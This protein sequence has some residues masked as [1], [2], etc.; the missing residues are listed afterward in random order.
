M[1]KLILQPKVN[2]YST[3]LMKD[4]EK[5]EYLDSIVNEYF[6]LIQWLETNK[7]PSNITLVAKPLMMEW[8][9]T[10]EF[11]LQMDHFFNVNRE[12]NRDY[13]VYFQLWLKWKKQLLNAISTFFQGDL[14]HLIPEPVS[15]FPLTHLQTQNGLEW[16]L[17]ATATLFEKQFSSKPNGIWLPYQSYIPGL[18]QFLLRFGF[19]YTFIPSFAFELGEKDEPMDALARSPRGL[20]LIPTEPLIHQNVG[21]CETKIISLENT[22]RW[23]SFVKE[24]QF[25]QTKFD[26]DTEQDWLSEYTTLTRMNFCYQGMETGLAILDDEQIR[27]ARI[28]QELELE[29]QHSFHA[30]QDEDM[31]NHLI[32]EWVYYLTSISDNKQD[33][34][35]LQSL[36]LLMKSIN[37][38]KTESHFLQHRKDQLLFTLP[39][40]TK[41]TTVP[42]SNAISV[43]ILSWEFPPNIVGGLSRHVYSLAKTLSRRGVKVV[44]LTS[45]SAETKA[46]EE[47][48]GIDVYRTGPLHPLEGNFINWVKDLNVSMLRKVDDII[49]RHSINIVHAHDWLVGHAALTMKRFYQIPLITTIHATEHG[50][51]AG[52]YT[53]MQQYIHNEES[54]L[55]QNSNQVIVCSD[56]MKD[57]VE[58][59]FLLGKTTISIIPNGIHL[60]EVEKTNGTRFDYLE[61]KRFVFSVGR[62]VREKGF[63]TLIDVASSLQDDLTIIVA[64]K[65]PL[66]DTYRNIVAERGLNE[67]I[68]FIGFI[69]DEERNQL[70]NTCEIAIFPSLYEPFGIVALE[71]MAAKKPVIASKI[72]GLKGIIQHEFSGLLFSPGVAEELLLMINQLNAS[73]ILQDKIGQQGFQVAKKLF[74][75]ERIADQTKQ[76]YEEEA[77]HNK[78]E[79]VFL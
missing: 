33:Q 55:I 50:R 72:G 37:K 69:T 22:K 76:V 26:Q 20:V 10:N 56:Y 5:E 49:N 9:S 30:L 13:Q 59:L 35:S 67:K 58:Q 1:I 44:V 61:Q 15:H 7:S 11:Q 42:Q 53:E 14:L 74:G 27:S 3:H 23:R 8:F 40:V 19:K 75:W 29:I 70:L 73:P 66:L 4:V 31:K 34:A 57:E 21:K 28:G 48:D 38:G 25:Y 71:A 54:E 63:E 18:D 60:G 2:Y 32:L 65:G 62:V 46:Y 77:L 12:K 41:K 39:L 47:M 51:N 68:Q 79:G 16:Q 36:Q 43:L 24:M 78:M 52:I 17:E 6:P 45:H 64:G